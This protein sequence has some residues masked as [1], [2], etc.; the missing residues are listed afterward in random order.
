MLVSIV[1][2]FEKHQWLVYV[3]IHADIDQIC[4]W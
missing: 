2:E 3:S 4:N 1:A